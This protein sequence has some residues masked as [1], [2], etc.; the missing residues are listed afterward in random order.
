MKKITLNIQGMHCASCSKLIEGSLE[1]V[2]KSVKINH[3]TG[4]SE[5]EFDEKKT[6]EKQ[7]KDIVI[8]EGFKIK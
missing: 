8:K 4:I 2:V 1:T 3:I 6:S 5:I 7:I